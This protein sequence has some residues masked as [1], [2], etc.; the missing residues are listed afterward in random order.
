MST[1]KAT[2][3]QVVKEF[4]DSYAGIVA[5]SKHFK[6]VGIL[7]SKLCEAE[8]HYQ[9]YYE[10]ALEI[11]DITGDVRIPQALCAEFGGV[12]VPDMEGSGLNPGSLIMRALEANEDAGSLCKEL[13]AALA[14]SRIDPREHR[15]LTAKIQSFKE[16]I[17]DIEKCI[18]ESGDRP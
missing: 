13:H 5:V 11:Y 4:K 10:D 16:A 3:R 14:D 2:C 18:N 1:L 15:I 12:F 7:R 17:A 8:T 9:F 6:K